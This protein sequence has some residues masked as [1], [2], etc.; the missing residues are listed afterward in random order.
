M[1]LRC[2]NRILHGILED[3]FLEFKCRSARCG[4]GRGVVVIHRFSAT[5]GDLL[6]TLVFKD[7]AMNRKV[8]E[9]NGPG[10]NRVAVWSA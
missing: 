1:E 6:E 4:A 3:G 10:S 5:S 9:Q 2:G 7:P 8:G